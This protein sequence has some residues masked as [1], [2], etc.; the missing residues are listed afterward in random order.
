MSVGFDNIAVVVWKN[1][2]QTLYAIG[3]LILPKVVD[4][5]MVK[6]LTQVLAV[7]AISG[8]VRMVRKG[9]MVPY[10]LFGLISV[11]ILLVW[12]FPPMSAWCFPCFRWCWRASSLNWNTSSP[13]SELDC[14]IRTAASEWQPVCSAEELA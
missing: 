7:A 12:H 14:A 2:D 8:I 11:A 1:L 13:T 5:S 6:I 9:V 4:L 10:A 3:S